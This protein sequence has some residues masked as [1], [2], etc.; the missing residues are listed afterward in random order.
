MDVI[1]HQRDSRLGSGTNDDGFINDIHFGHGLFVFSQSTYRGAMSGI[2]HPSSSPISPV[3]SEHITDTDPNDSTECN[4]LT[5][6]F[7]LDILKT[8][9]AN[10]TVVTIGSPSG[11][12]ATAS[13]TALVESV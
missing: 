7:R 8:P 12:A 9:R 6:A 4:F 2:S 10:V 1:L 13:D 3:L 11:M 5:M